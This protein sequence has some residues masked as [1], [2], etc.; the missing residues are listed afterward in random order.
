MIDYSESD[1]SSDEDNGFGYKCCVCKERNQDKRT[2]NL[3]YR[4]LCYWCADEMIDNYRD[5]CTAFTIAQGYANDYNKK[6]QE[7][8]STLPYIK[9]YIQKQYDFIDKVYKKIN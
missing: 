5:L 3:G 8:K 6:I 4:Y 9:E 1:S 2:H 7:D